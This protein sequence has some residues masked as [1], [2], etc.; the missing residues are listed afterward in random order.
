VVN[1]LGTVQLHRRDPL[2]PDDAAKIVDHIRTT[3]ASA[4]TA[5]T[6][7]SRPGVIE[8]ELINFKDTQFFGKIKVGTPPREFLVIFDTGSA[9]MWFYSSL[10][11]Q[12]GCREHQ[13]YNHDDSPTYKADGRALMIRYGSGNIDG[14]ISQDIVAVGGVQLLQNFIEVTDVNG[15]AITKAKP[16]GIVGMAFPVLSVE[17]IAPLFDNAMAKGLVHQPIFSFHLT[18][19]PGQHGSVLLGGLDERFYDG[20]MAWIPLSSES[21]WEIRMTDISVAGTRMNLCPPDGCK[22]AVDTGTSLITGPSEG[23]DKLL[24][25]FNLDATCDELARFPNVTFHI[26][27]HDFTLSAEQYT[28]SYDTS[29]GEHCVMGF[30]P[31]DVPPPRGP[32]W[33]LGDVF[34]RAFYSVFDRGQNRVGF[35]KSRGTPLPKV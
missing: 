6:G 12:P 21:Y 29:N 10:C 20:E 26:M 15:K 8:D 5:S 13:Q 24:G 28:I 14:F 2:S 33:V 27:G 1:C 22:V 30:M 9:D 32:I 34:M 19:D 11:L 35:A 7:S 4:L 31:L 17:H 23:L 3:Q 18:N 25:K 16:D